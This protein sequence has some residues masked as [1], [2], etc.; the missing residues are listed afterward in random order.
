MTIAS[1]VTRIKTN[2]AQAYTA[3]EEKGATIP[4][5]KNSDNLSDA[6]ESITTGGAASGTMREFWAVPN[7]YLELDNEMTNDSYLKSLRARINK[8][9]SSFGCAFLPIT[10]DT[11]TVQGSNSGVQAIRTSDG[12]YQ[13]LSNGQTYT[14]TWDS[15]KDAS[16]GY[17]WIIY[18]HLDGYSSSTT[19][20]A[21]FSTN[22]Q[23]LMGSF[24]TYQ[25][26][27]LS[28]G[29]VYRYVKYLVINGYIKYSNIFGS[30]GSR[31]RGFDSFRTIGDGCF[32]QSAVSSFAFYHDYNLAYMPSI[33][34]GLL[35]IE[36]GYVITKDSTPTSGSYYLYNYPKGLDLSG[37]TDETWTLT[38]LS[39]VLRFMYVKIPPINIVLSSSSNNVIL[40]KDN[41]Q[42]IA[43]HA[44]SVEGKTLTM[45]KVNIA[46]C[47][48]EDSE[49]I[50]TLKNK[51]W[52]IA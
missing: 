5:V 52:T 38:N 40:S 32:S 8:R 1:E 2:I 28:Y 22:I 23:S 26:T 20:N 16:D 27:G 18:Y 49:I 12:F 31:V 39:S 47:G 25:D 24:Y 30:F 34:D 7:S 33:E 11:I 14:H 13:E 48:G 50:T 9:M 10:G 29:E 37:I 6:I 21:E 42:Y 3:L 46:T 36:E 35:K 19:T 51:G 15:S 17:R 4:E 44:P 45:G 43:E 41:W